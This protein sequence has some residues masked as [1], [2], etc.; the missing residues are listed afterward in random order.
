MFDQVVPVAKF[1]KD[2]FVDFIVDLSPALTDTVRKIG[3]IGILVMPTKRGMC[4]T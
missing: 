1:E 3:Q 2:K 4:L